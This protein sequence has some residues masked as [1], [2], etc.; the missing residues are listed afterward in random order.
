MKMFLT[1]NITRKVAEILS[2]T[3]KKIRHFSQKKML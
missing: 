2:N 3:E 1:G